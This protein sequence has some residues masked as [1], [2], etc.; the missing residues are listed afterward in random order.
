MWD[1]E[2]VIYDDFSGDTM[3]LDVVMAEIFKRLTQAAATQAEIV[4][5][6]ASEL[7]LEVDPRL[8]R[9]TE[10]TLGRFAA[11]GLIVAAEGRGPS[12][13]EG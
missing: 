2:I 5:Y 13:H 3:K 7:D 1:G 4:A 12:H 6:L 8:E 10:I 9:L 11:S